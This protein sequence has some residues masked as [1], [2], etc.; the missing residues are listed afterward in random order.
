MVHK[1]SIVFD[2]YLPDCEDSLEQRIKEFNEIISS[3]SRGEGMMEDDVEYL[4]TFY[5]VPHPYDN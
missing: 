5:D 1:L 2:D 3:Q 4:H